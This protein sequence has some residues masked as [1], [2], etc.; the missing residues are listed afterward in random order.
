MNFEQL[1]KDLASNSAEGRR[2]SL[3]INSLKWQPGTLIEV[4]ALRSRRDESGRKVVGKRALKAFRCPETGPT[5]FALWEKKRTV[6]FEAR[7]RFLAYGMVRGLTYHQIEK[8]C[9]KGNLPRSY[10]I[11]STLTRYLSP[12]QMA[13]FSEE[14][15]QAWLD[16]EE[17]P[18]LAK[19]AA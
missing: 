10:A 16:G 6:G 13:L 14:T 5:R 4:Q 7:M 8:T 11:H 12:E 3:E 19:E 15:I 1:K 17:V 18:K 9:S 2:I